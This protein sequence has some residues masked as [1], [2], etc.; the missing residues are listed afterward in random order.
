MFEISLKNIGSDKM[1]KKAAIISTVS[2]QFTLFEKENI[3]ILKSLGYEVHC[4]ANYEDASPELDSLGIIQHHIDIRRSPYSIYNIKAFFQLLKIM[5]KYKFDLVHC[6][7]PMGG[8]LGRICAWLIGLK[9]VIYTAHGFHFYK[10]APLINNIV[11]KNIERLLARITDVLI[12]INK[13]DYE[14]AQKFKM[15]KNGKVY[16]V[17]GVGV[18]V[19]YIKRVEVDKSEKRKELGIPEDGFVLVSVGELIPRKNHSQVIKAL[20]KIDIRDKNI[21]YLIVGKGALE[22]KLK[23]LSKKLNVADRVLFLGYRKD[24]IEILKASDLFIFPSRQEG[25]PK[26]LMEAMACGLPVIATKIRGNVDLVDDGKN[27]ILVDVNNIEQTRKAIIYLFEKKEL[28]VNMSKYN[29]E[30][31][32]NN[33]IKHVIKLM[34][35]IYGEVANYE[36]CSK[37]RLIKME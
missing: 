34:N 15:R 13:E 29:Q 21:Y 8:V 33:D 2:R 19:E 4:I 12:T 16:Y 10:G 27:G 9:P 20:S 28:R 24:V 14:A 32:E 6:H 1:Q 18:D 11:Y 35:E 26:A 5:K 31:I 22:L 17:P 3:R 36:G 37:N 7:S 23:K 30:R 25:L